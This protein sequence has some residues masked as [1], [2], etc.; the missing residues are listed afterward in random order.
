MRTDLPFRVGM[1]TCQM[2][3]MAVE[4]LDHF[5]REL[6]QVKK[7]D[8]LKIIEYGSGL[9]T[10]IFGMLWPDD[11][12]I[13]VEENKDWYDKVKNWLV[14]YEVKNVN[15][16]FE[17]V[18]DRNFYLFD[19]NT[20]TNYFHNTEKF[21]P[22]D[23]ILNDGNLREYIGESILN[24]AD[25]FIT[26][27]GLYLRHD[28]EKSFQHTWVGPHVFDFDWVVDD[29]FSYDMFCATHPG[30]ELLT[31]NGNGKWGYKAELGGVWRVW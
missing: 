27:G 22:F 3:P 21:K 26:E 18:A 19:E 23:L 5:V 13:S 31:V 25:S 14:K 20:N 8:K 29:G 16:I 9:S 24:E 30:Y 28:Y 12:I 7:R 6:K 11:E 4:W 17:E 10:V 1:E 2:S 15:L